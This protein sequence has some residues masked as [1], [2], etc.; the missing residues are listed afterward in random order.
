MIKIQVKN[1]IINSD[2]TVSWSDPLYQQIWNRLDNK[3]KNA[4]MKDVNWMK[5]TMDNYAYKKKNN[6]QRE[7]V[8]P[9]NLIIPTTVDSDGKYNLGNEVINNIFN[10][11]PEIQ[12][13]SLLSMISKDNKDANSNKMFLDSLG[14]VVGHNLGFS[15]Y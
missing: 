8:L 5:Y 10:N 14:L 7:F 4:L 13:K 1:Y 11:A 6:L 3:Y 12:K 15:K 9:E 2:N